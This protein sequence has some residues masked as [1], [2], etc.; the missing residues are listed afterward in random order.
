M[1]SKETLKINGRLFYGIKEIQETV[2]DVVAKD[3][4]S[5][6]KASRNQVYVTL[7]LDETGNRCYH[8]IISKS[9][10]IEAGKE[11]LNK[12]NKLLV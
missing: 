2:R 3:K 10:K 7:F 4:S 8:R 12:I 6:L 9:D 11:I 1:E 5:E